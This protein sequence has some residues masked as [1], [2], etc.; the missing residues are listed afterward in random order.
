MR[1]YGRRDLT[2]GTERTADTEGKT[3]NRKKSSREDAK[4]EV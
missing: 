1:N 4:E 2:G 3:N